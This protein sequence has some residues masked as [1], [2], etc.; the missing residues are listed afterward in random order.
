VYDFGAGLGYSNIFPAGTFDY[1]TSWSYPPLY[2]W[3]YDTNP[4][5][6]YDTP[7]YTT[8]YPGYAS[9]VWSWQGVLSSNNFV[10][11]GTY[12]IEQPPLVLDS[13]PMLMDEA[14][15]AA[16]TLPP[17]DGRL[18]SRINHTYDVS[19]D[20]TSSLDGAIVGDFSA[21]IYAMRR[22]AGTNPAALVSR[23]SRLADSL[24]ADPNLNQRTMY[25]RQVFSNPPTRIVSEAD[26]AFMVGALSAAVGD[27]E[28]AEQ[29][30]AAA[31]AAG[32]TSP[33][34]DLLRR[35]IRGEQLTPN[36]PWVPGRPLEK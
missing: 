18:L 31:Q 3:Q 7:S 36:G 23:G 30:L 1:T 24:R 32:D 13:S 2:A 8:S 34:T 17:P 27:A 5:Y 9:D 14:V 35:A 33:S 20:F 26:A 25:V 22:A 12:T 28:L 21:S 16:P 4:I 19:P 6:T 15:P 29:S 11:G 10:T